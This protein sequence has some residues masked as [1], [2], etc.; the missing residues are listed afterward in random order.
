MSTVRRLVAAAF[1]LATSASAAATADCSCTG[2]AASLDQAMAGSS[3]VFRAVVVGAEVNRTS[4]GFATDMYLSEII[5]L[6][7]GKPPFSKLET[8]VPSA[9]GLRVEVPQEYWFFA[10]A[11]GEIAPC[12]YSGPAGAAAFAALES[13]VRDAVAKSRSSEYDSNGYGR[14]QTGLSSIPYLAA[15]VTTFVFLAAVLWLR[16][17]Q[18]R[19][20]TPRPPG[21]QT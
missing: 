20:T 15:A 16:G 8:A 10:T 17:R 5:P 18:A 12:S 2:A 14:L 7:G 6:K 21:Q 1:A 4:G 11:G 3:Y 13:Q 9:C 19:T